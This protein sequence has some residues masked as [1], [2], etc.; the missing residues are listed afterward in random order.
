MPRITTLSS[1]SAYSYFTITSGIPGLANGWISMSTNLY[2]DIT[3]TFSDVSDSGQIITIGADSNTSTT[4]TNTGRIIN[5]HKSNGNIYWAVNYPANTWIFASKVSSERYETNLNDVPISSQ[6]VYAG[7]VH[8]SSSTALN[9]RTNIIKITP[10]GTISFQRQIAFSAAQEMFINDMRSDYLGVTF[11]SASNVFRFNNTGTTVYQKQYNVPSGHDL[12]FVRSCEAFDN[13]SWFTADSRQYS[14]TFYSQVFSLTSTGSISWNNQLGIG[15]GKNLISESMCVD[16]NKNVYLVGRENSSGTT[17]GFVIKLTDTG[18]LSW[19]KSYS[20]TTFL[21]VVYSKKDDTIYSTGSDTRNSTVK[22]I[23]KLYSNGDIEY[24]KTLH[25]SAGATNPVSLF[26][27]RQGYFYIS[28]KDFV[29][30]FKADGS[31]TGTYALANTI[32]YANASSSNITVSNILSSI[33]NTVSGAT[34]T[35]STLTITTPAT[36]LSNIS[37]SDTVTNLDNLIV[38]EYLVVAGGGSSA[39]S[40]TNYRSSG[41]GGAGGYLTGN[42]SIQLGITYTVTVGSGGSLATFPSSGVYGTNGANSSIT[43]AGLTTILTYGGGAGGPCATTSAAGVGKSGGSGGGGGSQLDTDGGGSL[44]GKGVYSGSTFVSSTI[45]QGFDGGAGN[46]QP[47]GLNGRGGGGGGGG[48]GDTGSGTSN[49]IGGNGGSG[50]LNSITGTAVTYS[51]GGRGGSSGA[52]AVAGTS[53]A[54]N[55]GNGAVGAG[56]TASF[57]ADGANGG[58][59]VVVIRYPDNIR[60]ATSTTGSPTV[61]TSG[62]FRIYTF[63]GS[64]SITI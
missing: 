8:A 56:S 5:R 54:V 17:Q 32:T 18:S 12:S 14:N 37:F 44:G 2:R 59:G 52:S 23:S 27:D 43:G 22:V 61:T 40:A 39:A 60:A 38:S 46:G 57:G 13:V 58:S 30:K 50:E 21:T 62:G 51:A 45:R 7:I 47:G 6:N 42:V 41:G 24:T 20:N 11:V 64:G 55:T 25:Y 16:S 26:P 48:R 36:S 9:N 4:L 19:A 35:N 15:I 53:G 63:T 28:T 33:T 1:V 31:D 10:S 34:L 29:T 49:S 3:G